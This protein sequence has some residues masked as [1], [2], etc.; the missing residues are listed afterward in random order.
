MKVLEEKD[1]RRAVRS[2]AIAALPRPL[3]VKEDQDEQAEQPK[4]LAA[5]E[6]LTAALVAKQ[7]T[8]GSL[9]PA[10][11]A[12]AEQMRQFLEN[13][14]RLREES[15]PKKSDEWKFTL[16]RGR[17]DLLTHITAKRQ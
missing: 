1:V 4:L 10:F 7:A 13:V 16:H 5:I 6:K 11:Y 17:N 2:K 9:G 3:P 14:T 8:D 15:Q 12:L